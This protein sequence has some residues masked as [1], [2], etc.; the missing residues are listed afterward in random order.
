MLAVAAIL[1]FLNLISTLSVQDSTQKL[2]NKT[3]RD[4]LA[5]CP[6]YQPPNTY[7]GDTEVVTDGPPGEPI[8]LRLF[9]H[10]T[11]AQTV[12]VIKNP[13]MLVSEPTWAPDGKFIV[14]V[15]K[16][17]D[18][19]VRNLWRIDPDGNNMRQITRFTDPKVH[20]DTPYISPDAK[21][22]VFSAQGWEQLY[23]ASTD[24]SNTHIFAEKV[25]KEKY[26]EQFYF[27]PT[28]VNGG[29]RLSYLTTFKSAPQIHS[30]Q[31]VNIDGSNKQDITDYC[32]SAGIS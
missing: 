5:L 24:G 17:F 2:T 28:F 31:V 9:F 22:V 1:L 8:E 20:P 27:A 29:S 23:L 26:G 32:D 21:R 13:E 14:F 18:S 3:W 12:I 10:N 30:D 25:F 15:G 6:R 19:E 11:N 16:P 7:F 4:T